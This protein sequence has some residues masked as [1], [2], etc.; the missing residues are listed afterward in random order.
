TQSGKIIGTVSYMSPEQIRGEL[1]DTRSDIF[2]FGILLYRMV[3][4]KM[5]FE[6]ETQV[7]TMAKILEAQPETPQSFNENLPA[8]LVR[9]IEKCLRKKAD[10]R[11]QDTRDLVVDLRNLR[12]QFDSDISSRVTG[13]SQIQTRPRKNYT[14]N[15]SPKSLIIILPLILI[16]GGILMQILDDNP[17]GSGPIVFAGENGLAILGFNNKT[18]NEE[19]SWLETGLPEILQTDL[20]ENQSITIINRDRVVQCLEDGST[21]VGFGHSHEDCLRAA[22]YLGAKHAISGAFYKVGDQIRIDARLEELATGKI[23]LTEKV[24]GS[25][26]FALVDS[27][28]DKIAASLN[29]DSGSG[30]T[31]IASLTS[32][33]PEAYRIYLKAMNDFDIEL[34]DDAISGFKEALRIDSSFALPYM[35]IGM[36]HVFEGRIQEGANWFALARKFENKLPAKDRQLLDI[37]ANLW[38]DRQFDEAFIKMESLVMNYPGDKETRTFYG[39]LI[40]FFQKDTTRAFAQLDTALLMDPKYMLALS[41]Y[42]SMYNDLDNSEEAIKYASLAKSYYPRS[43]SPNLTLAGIYIKTSQYDKAKDEY[44]SLLDKI[45][46]HF[47]AIFNTYR[48]NIFKRDFPEAKKYIDLILQFHKNDNY[49]L[50]EYYNALSN[51]NFWLGNITEYFNNRKTAINYILATGDSTLISNSY[52]NIAQM[53][54]DFDMFDSCLYYARKGYN[55]A[56]TFQAVD[57]PLT[58]VEI[59]TSLAGDARPIFENAIQTFRTSLPSEFWPLAEGLEEAFEAH[60]ARDTTRLIQAYQKVLNVNPSGNQAIRRIIGYLSSLTGQNDSAIVI[61]SEYYDNPGKT[62]S[63][64][65]YLKILY[66]LGRAYEGLNDTEKAAEIF[67]EILRSWDK[68]DIEIDYIE[69][70]REY[71]NRETS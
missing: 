35:R 42:S 20:A 64:S 1:I 55:W 29:L 70:A 14:L 66:H 39:L 15:L 50:F 10:D 45:P 7:S 12:R 60:I 54:R 24:V 22:N 19:L 37:Y 5:P 47:D 67:R 53:F 34:F 11:Y 9:I 17:S 57:Y 43:P 25:D 6:G 69:Y 28:T 23:I 32:S 41:Q 51:Y 65:S 2:S 59:D 68:T 56:N 16:I 8:E 3:T 21:H 63:G 33:S 58:M 26:P 61:L 36:A 48:I 44:S 18:G 71:L 38:L 40:N 52:V 49:K 27:L 62:S 13:I 30:Q 4:G 31:Q 46:D